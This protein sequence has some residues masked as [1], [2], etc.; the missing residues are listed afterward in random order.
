MS[1][2]KE[3]SELLPY[4]QSV[5]KLKNYLSF[6]VH[7]PNTWKLPKRFV[8]EDKVME[9]ESSEPNQRLISFVTQITEEG[10]EKTSINIRGIIKYNLE[11][12][13][14]ERLFKLKVSEL[15][16]IFENGDIDT[17]R[18]LKF[19]TNELTSLNTNGAKQKL[20]PASEGNGILEGGSKKI[21]QD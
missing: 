5:R 13:E 10:V 20:T 8:E 16:G 17:L 7:I 14:K 18:T 4:L 12:E 11:R 15:K 3:F 6:D 19:D 9:Q 1:L 2:Y 21:K